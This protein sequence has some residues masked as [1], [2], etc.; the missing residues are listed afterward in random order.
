MFQPDKLADIIAKPVEAK[1]AP[2]TLES[3][4]AWLETKQA[5]EEYC[6][7]R[8]G[9]C[10]IAHYLKEVC[11]YARPNIGSTFYSDLDGPVR[12]RDLPPKWDDI[13]LRGPHTFGAALIRARAYQARGA[14]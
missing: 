5:D 1:P 12:M 7:S 3:L 10:L 2:F 14:V 9:E 4:I 6:Y 8:T 11:G 13:A